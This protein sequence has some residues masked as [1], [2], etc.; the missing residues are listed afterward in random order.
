MRVPR[1]FLLM[2]LGYAVGLALANV[3]VAATGL[4]QPALLY[5]VPCTLGL[6][7][8]YARREGSL[9][10]LWRGPPA[11]EAAHAP[12]PRAYGAQAT[13]APLYQAEEDA[14]LKTA[15]FVA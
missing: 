3:A 9:P 12:P 4:G 10:L 11:L 14:L 13:A 5:L 7:L 2:V 6:F 8:A 1:H 15:Q